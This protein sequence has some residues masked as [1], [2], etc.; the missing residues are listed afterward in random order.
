[1]K[2]NT[3][4]IQSASSKTVHVQNH[5]FEKINISEHEHTS[6]RYNGL[7]SSNSGFISCNIFFEKQNDHRMQLKKSNGLV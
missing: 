5:H 6:K 3:Q 4:I 1:M 7:R 2:D